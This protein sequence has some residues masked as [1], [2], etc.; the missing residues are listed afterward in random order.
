MLKEGTDYFLGTDNISHFNKGK[1]LPLGVL[2][3]AATPTT[4]AQPAQAAPPRET[5]AQT[6]ARETPA[7]GAQQPT[8]NV[9]SGAATQT[10]QH[11]IWPTD[12]HN[13]TGVFASSEG[14]SH[15]HRGLDIGVSDGTPVKAAAAG[16]VISTGDDNRPGVGRGL[17]VYIDHGN[18][19]HSVYE[20]LSKIEVSDHE[21]VYQGQ[22]IAFSGKT[23]GYR[24]HLHFE[25]LME[26]NTEAW[27]KYA[28]G[29]VGSRRRD[30]TTINTIEPPFN[31]KR[32]SDSTA[33]EGVLN[34]P[35]ISGRHV[36]PEQYLGK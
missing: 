33:V 14:R 11:L 2:H 5:P 27:L 4:P 21:T 32:D 13:I 9:P 35:G 16:K 30:G 3:P 36:D 34:Y 10:P 15:F 22:N 28:E 31:W 23:Y 26:V 18:G 17:Y 6:P 12:S 7:P 24:A 1:T 19:M 20:H 29:R 8:Q 25:L